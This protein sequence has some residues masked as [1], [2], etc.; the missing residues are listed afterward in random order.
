MLEEFWA[1]TRSRGIHHACMVNGKPVVTRVGSI[2][3]KS[4]LIGQTLIGGSVVVITRENGLTTYDTEVKED[5]RRIY[6][7]RM[8]TKLYSSTGPIL[9]LT[10]Q[11]EV[12]DT[13]RSTPH[14]MPSE[15]ATE[16]HEQ[17]QEVLDRIGTDHPGFMIA[18]EVLE[19]FREAEEPHCII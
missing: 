1:L 15:W 4:R 13:I 12:F 16:F 2:G 17:T 9:L 6:Q 18:P 10:T 8:S 11:R 3:L 7:D 14:R 5:E 19:M